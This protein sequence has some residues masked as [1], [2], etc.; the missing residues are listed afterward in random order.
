MNLILLI[1]TFILILQSINIKILFDL[2]R[3]LHEHI[4]EHRGYRMGKKNHQKT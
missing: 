2:Q 1:I 3:K 4:D